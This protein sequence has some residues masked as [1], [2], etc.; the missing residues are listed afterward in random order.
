MIQHPEIVER[1]IVEHTRRHPLTLEQKFRL[2][3]GMQEEVE[4]LRRYTRK[5]I[6]EGLSEKIARVQAMHAYAQNNPG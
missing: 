6:S 5:N 2:F 4:A 1:T 3:D